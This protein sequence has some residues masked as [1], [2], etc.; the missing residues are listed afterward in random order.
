M[1]FK[2]GENFI[3]SRSFFMKIVIEYTLSGKLN[4][5]NNGGI[6]SVLFI[7]RAPYVLISKF[8]KGTYFC[9]FSISSYGL[10]MCG[11]LI[12]IMSPKLTKW[13]IEMLKVLLSRSSTI[14]IIITLILFQLLRPKPSKC[15]I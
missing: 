13:T 8:Y 11:I 15:T 7:F 3:C 4:N 6:E 9:G 2:N 10:F 12:G 1:N 5:L 14:N